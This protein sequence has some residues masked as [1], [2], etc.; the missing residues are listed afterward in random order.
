MET[1]L[2]ILWNKQLGETCGG[3]TQPLPWGAGPTR[4]TSACSQSFNSFLPTCGV[5][6]MLNSLFQPS[7][8][9]PAPL[10]FQAPST[11]WRSRASP[12][13]PWTWRAP[14]RARAC[15]S[16]AWSAKTVRC[17]PPR[18]TPVCLLLPCLEAA[19]LGTLV[20]LP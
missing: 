13:S 8:P 17:W 14:W 3:D 18:S 6:S 12:M 5:F 1:D 16:S 20:W 11:A 7:S 10:V 9:P 4:Q 15:G 2:I 19:C